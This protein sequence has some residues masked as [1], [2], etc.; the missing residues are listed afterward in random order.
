MPAL[1]A[2][3]YAA[4]ADRRRRALSTSGWDALIK[5]LLPFNSHPGSHL[6]PAV[7]LRN[8]LI[9]SAS[10]LTAK[11]GDSPYLHENT[12]QTAKA[13]FSF[14]YNSFRGFS[15]RTNVPLRATLS[16]CFEIVLPKLLLRSRLAQSCRSLAQA[17]G[18]PGRP[19]GSYAE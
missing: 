19:G 16:W 15:L 8:S 18:L 14:V 6:T 4:Y 11:P 2:V 5:Q 7:M 13:L 10:Y 17:H 12:R 3:R 9:F 1:F